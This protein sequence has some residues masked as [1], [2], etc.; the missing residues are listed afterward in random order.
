MFSPQVFFSKLT[1]K[2][3]RTRKKDRHY[4]VFRLCIENFLRTHFIH[5]H[6]ASKLQSDYFAV[7]PHNWLITACDHI[8]TLSSSFVF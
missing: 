8:P 1:D 3:E 6:R 5:R 2:K 4:L 7:W